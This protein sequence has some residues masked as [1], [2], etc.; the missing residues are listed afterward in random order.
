MFRKA[1][2]MR[3]LEYEIQTER[4]LL[5][6]ITVEDADAVWKW[7]SDERVARYMV[8]P[9]YR[10]KERL[11]EWLRSIEVFDGEFE[12]LNGTC[13]MISDLEDDRMDIITHYDRLIEEDNDP[14][15]DPPAWQK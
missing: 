11:I 14:F 9:T 4:L 1:N 13:K 3:A 10:D 2:K 8:Y 15:R 5:R 7:V 12:K 6:P